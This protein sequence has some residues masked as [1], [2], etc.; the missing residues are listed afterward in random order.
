MLKCKRCGREIIENAT[1]AR[2]VF[3]GMHWLCFHLEYEHNA[4]PDVAC[5]DPS[6]PWVQIADL[7]S[8]LEQRGVDPD[9]ELGLAIERR[10]RG[11]EPQHGD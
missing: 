5:G 4:D 3:E 10:W 11:S 1:L 7:R 9:A 8:S 6:C 2:D